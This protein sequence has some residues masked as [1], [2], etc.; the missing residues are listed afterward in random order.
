MRVVSDVG[1]I[2]GFRV[3]QATDEFKGPNVGKFYVPVTMLLYLWRDGTIGQS[4]VDDNENAVGWF[5][6]IE[7]VRAVIAKNRLLA[8]GNSPVEGKSCVR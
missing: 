6:T 3:R 8:G 4:T 7:D 5:D 2:D 1:T